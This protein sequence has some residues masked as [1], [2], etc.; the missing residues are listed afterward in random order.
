MQD[1]KMVKRA[2]RILSGQ[3]PE[4]LGPLVYT[5]DAEGVEP[6]R[7]PEGAPLVL[8]FSTFTI[9]YFNTTIMTVTKKVD[10][11]NRVDLTCYGDTPSRWFRLLDVNLT[12]EFIEG[13]HSVSWEDDD[14]TCEH[15]PSLGLSDDV[16][17]DL[18]PK[19]IESLCC[20][21]GIMNRSHIVESVSDRRKKSRQGKPVEPKEQKFIKRHYIVLDGKTCVRQWKGAVENKGQVCPHLRRAHLRRL[22]DGRMVRVSSSIVHRDDFKWSEHDTVYRVVDLAT[23]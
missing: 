3:T 15:S 18:A 19:M 21:L 5:D 14:L 11:E 17:E 13:V 10:D 2:R 1:S 20:V 8:P 12:V 9:V 7:W 4:S 16:L 22:G 23:D 6:S